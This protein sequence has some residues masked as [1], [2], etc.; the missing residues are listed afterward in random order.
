MNPWLRLDA[1]SE[2]DSADDGEPSVVEIV[3]DDPWA[4]ARAAVIL[5][6]VRHHVPYSR[7]HSLTCSPA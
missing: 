6:Q 2:G 1:D 4:A 3:S 7:L 5:K